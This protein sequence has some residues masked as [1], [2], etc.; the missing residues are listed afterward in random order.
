MDK[1]GYH[2]TTVGDFHAWVGNRTILLVCC[3]HTGPHF[4]FIVP[5]MS[6]DTVSELVGD[7][8][9]QCKKNRTRRIDD[10]ITST[11]V[12]LYSM[13]I[14]HIMPLLAKGL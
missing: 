3:T 11:P 5:E 10:V 8:R 9:Q 2:W 13:P 4:C 12:P 14:S 1:H 6:A 7:E